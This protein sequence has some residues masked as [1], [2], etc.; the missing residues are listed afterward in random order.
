MITTDYNL[1]R[2]ILEQPDILPGFRHGK[3]PTEEQL[4]NKGIIYFYEPDVGLF[5]ANILGKTLVMHAAIPKENRGKKAVNAAKRL[6]TYLTKNGYR[7][8]TQQKDKR[9]LKAF[10][11]MV[12]F[13]FISTLND[14]NIYLF[15]GDEHEP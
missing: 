5:P 9:H 2:S 7:V 6:A 1:I 4:Q 12:G 8:M 15:K 13:E 3:S 14:L 10:V 11:R